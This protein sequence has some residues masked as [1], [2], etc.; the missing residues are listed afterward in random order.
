MLGNPSSTKGSETVNQ[1]TDVVRDYWNSH[2]LGIQYQSDFS[3]EPGS[4]AFFEDIRPWMNPFKFPW[5]MERIDRE[6]RQ[7]QGKRLLEVGCGM[8]FDSLEFMKR[9][10]QVSAVDLTP[11]A[12]DFARQHFDI[13][14]A[15]PEYLAVGN[16]LALDFPDESFDAVWSN[17]V[18]HVTGNTPL[19][20]SEIRRVLKPGGRAIICH[21]YRK[22]SWMYLLH[23]LGRE[24]IEHKDEDPP[25]NDFYTEAEIEA[26]FEGFDIVETS[27]EHHR[28]LPVARKGLKATLYR[29]FFR[30][31]Y[32]LLPEPLALRFAYKYSVTAVKTE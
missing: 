4:K 5:I 18:V 6:S 17:G 20:I 1:A 10:V 27:R 21:F 14:G 15:H 16:A 13:V 24:N 3:A 12:I 23:R 32:N 29:W 25:V 22:P 2:P 8:G 28:A 30:P 31:L 19:A 7:L 9:G 11:A 26:M